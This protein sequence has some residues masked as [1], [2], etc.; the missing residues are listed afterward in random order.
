MLT[1]KQ[2]ATLRG[3]ANR[4]DTIFQVGKGGIGDELILQTDN[5]LK[6][7]E[8]IKMRVLET[9]EFSAREAAETLA[10]ATN[11][12]VVQVIGTKFILFKKKPKDSAF[13][14]LLK[15]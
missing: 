10:T 11:A 8:L 6:A 3:A 14:D 1:S 12:E 4:I 9:S 15:K 13:D 7:R 2:R 5:A